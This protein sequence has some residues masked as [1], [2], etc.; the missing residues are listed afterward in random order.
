MYNQVSQAGRGREMIPFIKSIKFGT[1]NVIFGKYCNII[2][3][4]S[5]KSIKVPL[6]VTKASPFKFPWPGPAGGAPLPRYLPNG[7][8]GRG[9]AGDDD[10]DDVLFIIHRVVM[11]IVVIII[12]INGDGSDDDDG[13]V[14]GGG[15]R[16]PRD[17]TTSINFDAPPPP[18]NS[19]LL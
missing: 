5:V 4:F 10:Y 3:F 7:A 13:D 2:R 16:M 19:H 14:R 8:G 12:I 15:K 18:T 11:V 1:Q 9:Y 6:Q 17:Q